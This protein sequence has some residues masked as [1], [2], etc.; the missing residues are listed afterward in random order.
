LALFYDRERSILD[1]TTSIWYNDL[2]NAIICFLQCQAALLNFN[3]AILLISHLV[4]VR[5]RHHKVAIP[6][7][8]VLYLLND[9]V[10]QLRPLY[11]LP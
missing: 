7:Q 4:S 5:C 3:R 6:Y 11:Y 8:R 2:T 10:V 1:G 9:D